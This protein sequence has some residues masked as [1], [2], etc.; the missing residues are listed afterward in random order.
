MAKATTWREKEKK[1]KDEEIKTP[2]RYGSHASMIV[3]ELEND[4]LVLQDNDGYYVTE[5]KR[6]DSGL[7]DTYRS[8][9][10]DYRITR[11]NAALL[12]N[13]FETLADFLASCETEEEEEAEENAD[14]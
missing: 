11:L 10:L 3:S 2:S 5:K 13:G 12:A 8:A 6:L 7:T 1:R 9:R 14:G 4:L